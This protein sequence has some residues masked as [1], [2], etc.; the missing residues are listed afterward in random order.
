MFYAQKR[1]DLTIGTTIG[2]ADMINT[3]LQNLE[4]EKYE[5]SVKGGDLNEACVNCKN[6]MEGMDI[7]TFLAL[8]VFDQ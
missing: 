2:R 7:S 4:N 6:N 3:S 5:T 8:N 1:L